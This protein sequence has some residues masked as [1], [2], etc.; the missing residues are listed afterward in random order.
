MMIALL[1]AA[2]LSPAVAKPQPVTPADRQMVLVVT[3][4]WEATQG[5]AFLYE[6]DH[7]EPWTLEAALGT[8]SVGRAGLGWGRTVGQLTDGPVKREGDGR[9]PA[10]V[11][12]L[13]AASGYAAAPPAGTRLPYRQSTEALRCVDDPRSTH[14][15]SWVEEGA[16]QKDW[17]SAEEMRRPDELYRWTIWVGHNDRRP[18]PGHG[19]CIF[20]HQRR[21]AGSVTD[22]CT[23][24]DAEPLDRL[25]AWLDPEARPVLVQLPLPVFRRVA[26]A[27]GLPVPE[28]EDGAPVAKD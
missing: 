8:V 25:L 24:L 15:N 22:G 13:S 6:R 2:S 1:L 18:V 26:K 10:G 12:P 14:Y 7:R 20:I 11:F 9:A 21:S 19:S 28:L 27:W 4:A 17:S 23:A 5:R 3:P 16:V